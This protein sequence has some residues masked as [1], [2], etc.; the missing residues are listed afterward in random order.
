MRI[1]NIILLLTLTGSTGYLVYPDNNVKHE[2]QEEYGSI[3]IARVSPDAAKIDSD[4]PSGIPP[5]IYKY[6]FSVQVDEGKAIALSTVRSQRVAGLR[7][8]QKHLVIIRDA[9]KIIESFWFRF[10]RYKTNDLCLRYG[11]GYQSWLLEDV[12]KGQKQCYCGKQY[13][14]QNGKLRESGFAILT[15]SQAEIAGISISSSVNELLSLLGKPEK[16]VK[17]TDPIIPEPQELYMY[18]GLEILVV[19]G[20]VYDVMCTDPRFKTSDGVSVGD[21]ISKVRN[22]YG[23]GEEYTVESGPLIRY[24]VRNS[25]T[26][27]IFHVEKDY[28]KAISLWFDFA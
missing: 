12:R 27:L 25:D 10:D 13:L 6:I 15:S 3:C 21:K 11:T 22:I 18:S 26:Y 1:K 17:E 7:T 20:E 2:V 19:A 24:N 28:V 4:Y 14:V 5:R 9:G 16:I 23:Q 8:D